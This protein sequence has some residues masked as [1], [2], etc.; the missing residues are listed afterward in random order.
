M[1]AFQEVTDR[2]EKKPQ[3]GPKPKQRGGRGGNRGAPREGGPTTYRPKT[4]QAK[5]E[6]ASDVDMSDVTAEKVQ[7]VPVKQEQRVTRRQGGAGQQVEGKEEEKKGGAGRQHQPR[8]NKSH[9]PSEEPGFTGE[10]TEWFDDIT[11]K[12]QLI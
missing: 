9:V 12:K 11:F 3:Q 8:K 7:Q 4:A 6:A 10:P 1:E 5:Q 2:R